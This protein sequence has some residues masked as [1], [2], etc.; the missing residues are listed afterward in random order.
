VYFL[1]IILLMFV[2]P[3]ASVLV[4]AWFFG[5]ATAI[6]FLI[7]KWFVFWAVGIRLFTAGLRQSVDPK[8][9]AERI[10]DIKRNEPLAIVQ[11]LGFANL[12]ISVLGISSILNS[13]WV[14][15][16]AIAGGLFYGLAAVRHLARRNKN[17]HEKSAMISDLFVSMVLIIYLIGVIIHASTAP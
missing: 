7:G 8:F 15:P 9:T 11:E 2:I 1:I 13:A 14:V 16:S 17:L 12:S 5:G 3:I 6:I 10:F 4:E